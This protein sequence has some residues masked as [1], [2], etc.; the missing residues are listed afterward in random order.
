MKKHLLVLPA[1]LVFSYA[2]TSSTQIIGK[3]QMQNNLVEEEYKIN[4][5]FKLPKL[6][7]NGITYSCTIE[8]PS[9]NTYFQ[10]E[11][12]LSEVGIYK[13]HYSA[14]KDG[15]FYTE[16]YS[17]LVRSPYIGFS[18][19]KSFSSYEKSDRTYNK[20]GLFVS[21]AE[22]ETL[23]FN[24]PISLSEDNDLINLFVAPN[25][26]GNLD[27]SELYITLTEVANPNNVLT[28][29]AKASPDG[30]NAPWTYW[31]GKGVGQQL[32][33]YE[34][35]F[36]NIH[37]NNDFGC[38]V[39]HSFYGQYASY[40]PDK[41][42]GDFTL[43]LRYNRKENA[44]YQD[45]LQIIDFDNPKYF[46]TL[47]DG[48]ETDLVTL[49]IYA[50]GYSSNSANFVI[51]N[52]LGKDLTKETI[53]D[54]K[55]PEIS[56]DC[57]Y[58]TV[59]FAKIG[60]RYPV[61]D[62]KAND[63]LDGECKVNSKVYF[64]YG[65]GREAIVPVNDNH[66]EVTQ[67]G[68]YSIVYEAS[69]R[70]GNVSKKV[71][72]I[73]VSDNVEDITITPNGEIKKEIKQGEVYSFPSLNLAGGSG[74]IDGHF[75]VYLN[76][77][78][79]E[80][81]EDSFIPKDKG[82]YKIE[83]VANDII[84]QSKTYSYSLEVKENDGAV[85]YEEIGMPRYFIS[86]GA[87]ILPEAICYDY[88]SGK[89][90]AVPMDVT[91]NNGIFS[92]EAKSG[93]TFVPKIEGNQENL[94]FTYHYKNLEI[95][96]DVLTINPYT[97]VNGIERFSIENFLISENLNFDIGDRDIGFYAKSKG[98]ASFTFA[99]SVIAEN[100]SILLESEPGKENFSRLKVSI[101][102][103]INEEERVTLTLDKNSDSSLTFK[104]DK[105]AY[106]TTSNLSKKGNL[107]VSYS[108]NHFSFNSTS[109][110]G[111]YYDNGKAFAGF[112]SNKVYFEV[113]LENAKAG[114]GLKLSKID[115]QS[116]SYSSSDYSEPRIIIYGDY[117][118]TYTHNQIAKINRVQ[119]SDVL[120]PNSICY[121]T[122]K[123]P[124]GNIVKDINGI[125]LN[126][127]N[128]NKDYDIKLDEYGQYII[129]YTALDTS[130]NKASFIYAIN[131]E[132]NIAPTINITGSMPT[133]V[134]VGENV[135]IP[136]VEVSD[137]QSENVEVTIFI[138][139]SHGE[140]IFLDTHN[141]FKPL[142]EGI[143]TLR[144]RAMDEAGN[145]AYASINFEV[146]K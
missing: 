73:K 121:V 86:D 99:N 29:R 126:E 80:A 105:R 4:T 87:Y 130:E 112:G 61:F 11:V 95:S 88:S 63:D 18:G 116:M 19:V 31:T 136:S 43:K 26:A 8:F 46:Q 27:F 141:A 82:T 129:T 100:S 70:S 77:A 68:I 145:V 76:D 107:Q 96:K 42:V 62:A 24:E 22:G 123:D 135:R 21:L 2:S 69:D 14:E 59:P 98:N 34:A 143:Y 134:K 94:H 139:T 41:H 85:L 140:I 142:F 71:I 117:G 1:L 118:G 132:D 10:E 138:E 9:G 120:D 106:L 15:K 110:E 51:L 39:T 6:E 33:G 144:I 84:G 81:K 131:V 103:S 124:N 64:N 57:P 79:Y 30:Q 37:V 113:T 127:A 125:S 133:T 55:G 78:A 114:A 60:H 36:G 91:I 115:N 23:T 20:E 5:L 65:S 75:N 97:K 89:G 17:F 28:A 38:P 67:N 16:E 40:F 137:D 104:I 101:V 109:V 108:N 45:S 92:Y 47:W 12:R 93:E 32:T 13:L 111:R 72:N 58:A 35:S 50:K 53:I 49:S 83:Y 3:M 54:N 146:T 90:V 48:F 66:F 7:K 44:I 74:K 52:T 25:V 119:A 56:V 122:V 128:A 102:D